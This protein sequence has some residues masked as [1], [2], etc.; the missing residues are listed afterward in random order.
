VNIA[1]TKAGVVNMSLS[2]TLHNL[3]AY[4]GDGWRPRTH[5]LEAEIGPIWESCGQR[6]EWSPLRAVLLHRPGEELA[7]DQNP[8]TLQMLEKIDPTLAMRQHDSM[9]DAYRAASVAVVYV[10]P[11]RLPPP[12][13]MFVADLFF[14]T[15]EG[16]VV[17]RPASRI[18]AGEERWVARRLADHGIPILRTVNGTGVFEGADAMWID[19]QTVLIGR[20]LRTNA[21]G[22]CQVTAVLESLGVRTLPVDLPCGTMHLMGMLRIVDRDLALAWPTRLAYRAVEALRDKGYRVHFLPDQSE[23]LHGN[24]LNFVTFGPRRILMPAGNPVTLAFYESLGIQCT[25][26]DISELTKAA[27]AVG[28]LTGILRREP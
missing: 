13:Q 26:V 9:A 7:S 8:N 27:G 22:A 3:A 17:G 14:M 18:R 24:S 10:A 12:N 15:P 23:V 20:G 19:A 6:D 21:E 28:C 2:T 5:S 16:A 25:Q 4:G 11:E 1:E